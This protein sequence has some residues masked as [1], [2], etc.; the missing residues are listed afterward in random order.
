MQSPVFLAHGVLGQWDEIVFLGV[1]VIFIVMMG[2][3]WVVSRMNPPELEE[4]TIQAEK[5]TPTPERFKLD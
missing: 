2:I 4:E 5:E 3:S 1:A